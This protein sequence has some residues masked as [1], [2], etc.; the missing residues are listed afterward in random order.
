MNYVYEIQ[1]APKKNNVEGTKSRATLFSLTIASVNVTYKNNLT[2]E[3]FTDH[4]HDAGGFDKVDGEEENFNKY[5][6]DHP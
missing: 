5:P 2:F 3:V 4:V 6:F 1:P